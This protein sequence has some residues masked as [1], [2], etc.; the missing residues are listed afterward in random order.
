MKAVDELVKQPGAWLEV[1][2]NTGIIVSSRV[3]LARNIRGRRFPGWAAEGESQRLLQDLIPVFKRLETCRDQIVLEMEALNRVEKEILIERHLVSRDLGEKKKGS[4]VVLR[5]DESIAIMINEEDHIRMQAMS[6]GLNL[7]KL[8]KLIDEVDSEIEKSVEYAFSPQLGYLTSC[9]SNVGTGIRASVMLHLPGLVLMNEINSIIKAV[10]K[11]GLAVRGMWGEGTDAAGNMFQI[12][13][14][15][16][17]GETEQ[18][19]IGRLEKIVQEINGHERNSRARLMEQ[20]ENQIRDHFG[21]AVGIL[22][23]ANL[24]NSKETLDMLSALRLGLD[25]GLTS[26]WQ[27]AMIDELFLLIQPGH[28]QKLEGRA[29]GSEKRDLARAKLIRQK[30]IVK[31]V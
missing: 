22:T 27:R 20:K 24:L 15:T 9:P 7:Q 21:R 13:N 1:G 3:R 4:A 26:R 16:T 18:T 23:N 14:Q 5:R 8:W 31:G 28:L 25:L 2:E 19:I 10:G 29:I 11:M 30:L 12:S 6:P 17:L